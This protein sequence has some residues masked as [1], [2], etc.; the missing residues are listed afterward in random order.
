[1]GVIGALYLTQFFLLFLDPDLPDLPPKTYQWED[2]R[3]AKVQG[4][5][6]WTYLKYTSS[7]E[8]VIDLK[9]MSSDKINEGAS[10][11]SSPV[12]NDDN[13][14]PRPPSTTPSISDVLK[15]V[16]H[17]LPEHPRVLKHQDSVTSSATSTKSRQ[18]SITHI[19]IPIDHTVIEDAHIYEPYDLGPDEGKEEYKKENE[20]IFEDVK[21]QQKPPLTKMLLENQSMSVDEERFYLDKKI[22]KLAS[23]D[24][25]YNKWSSSK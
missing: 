16:D 15:T 3:R 21:I 23:L 20:D 17:S 13:T 22:F 8:S 11:S 6:P 19:I 10:S 5:Y 1:M 7:D 18:S 2:I 25:D 24:E 9:K 12:H 14:P 4:G